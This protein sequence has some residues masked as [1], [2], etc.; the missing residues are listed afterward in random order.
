MTWIDRS[1]T[2]EQYIAFCN[3]MDLH[4]M[5]LNWVKSVAEGT[6]SL[7]DHLS[8]VSS[9][10]IKLTLEQLDQ[11]SEDDLPT[12]FDEILK[13]WDPEDLIPTLDRIVKS[14]QAWILQGLIDRTQQSDHESL[15]N[16]LEN[17]SFTSGSTIAQTRWAENIKSKPFTLDQAY[18]AFLYSPLGK[19]G[20]KGFLLERRKSTQT[21]EIETNI[22]PLHSA[23]WEIKAVAPLVTRL[24]LQWMRG[25]MYRL[26]SQ[27][28]VSEFDTNSLN[29]SGVSFTIHSES[30]RSLNPPIFL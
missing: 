8:R 5:T 9:P 13:E 15:I 26:N 29:T 10:G 25:F 20:Q 23:Y 28:L 1:P 14:M 4:R 17:S 3:L 24:H 6:L 11:L 30:P 18:N 12:S 22:L 16:I 2:H 21:I 19:S 27:I 7:P